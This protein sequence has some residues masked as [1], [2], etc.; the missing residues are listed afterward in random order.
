MT[1]HLELVLI[2]RQTEFYELLGHAGSVQH[3][4]P[5]ENR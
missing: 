5:I 1:L 4:E 3:P 2:I